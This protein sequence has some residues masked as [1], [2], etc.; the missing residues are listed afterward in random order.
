M[1]TGVLWWGV[2]EGQIQGRRGKKKGEQN[3]QDG[4]TQRVKKLL[5]NSKLKP[6]GLP[7]HNA[8][9][10]SE[11]RDD[12]TYGHLRR[13]VSQLTWLQLSWPRWFSR[14]GTGYRRVCCTRRGL[15]PVKQAG[16]LSDR[17]DE[18]EARGETTGHHWPTNVSTAKGAPEQPPRQGA[19]PR[20]RGSERAGSVGRH[21]ARC[22]VL[23]TGVSDEGAAKRFDETSLEQRRETRPVKGGKRNRDDQE[24]PLPQGV[25]RRTCTSTHHVRSRVES[26]RDASVSRL[27]LTGLSGRRASV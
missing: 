20:G 2:C 19:L 25:R 10:S 15:K 4:K 12:V 14:P 7:R 17:G 6:T 23:S 3:K 27:A 16:K 26:G 5:S 21:A 22:R 9:Y 13:G 1:Q 8:C 24:L 18:D 11:S